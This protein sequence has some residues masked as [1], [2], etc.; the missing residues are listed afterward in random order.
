MKVQI[1]GRLGA[2]S[3][4]AFTEVDHTFVMWRVNVEGSMGKLYNKKERSTTTSLADLGIKLGNTYGVWNPNANTIRAKLYP[5]QTQLHK[6]LV[7]Y[8][9]NME[10]WEINCGDPATLKIVAHSPQ[11]WILQLKD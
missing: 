4:T 8:L 5:N 9:I 1:Q 7:K 2:S 3:N 11:C 10:V 6:T